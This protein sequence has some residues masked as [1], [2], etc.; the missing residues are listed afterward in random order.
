MYVS[1]IIEEKILGEGGEITVIRKE[2]VDHHPHSLKDPK[3]I[4]LFITSAWDSYFLQ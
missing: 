2:G 1:D 4:V 3:P